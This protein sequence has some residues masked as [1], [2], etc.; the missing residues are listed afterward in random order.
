MMSRDVTAAHL[1]SMLYHVI[2]K[3]QEFVPGIR[4]E[5]E[6]QISRVGHRRLG[7]RARFPD[8]GWVTIVYSVRSAIHKH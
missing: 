8:V 7:G 1:M 2:Y 6:L 4:A 3:I 5:T